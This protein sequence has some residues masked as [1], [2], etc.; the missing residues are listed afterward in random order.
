MRRPYPVTAVTQSGM[1]E[2]GDGNRVYWETAGDP[3]GKPALVLHGG[4]GS[5]SVP[6]FR[7]F[8]DPERYRIVLFDQRGCGRSTPHAGDPETDLTV[9]TT[10]HLLDDIELLRRRLEIDRWLLFGLSWGSTLALAYAES[11]PDRV[12]EIVLG[13][14]GTTRP[15]EIAWLYH[16][17]GRFL[18]EQWERFRSGAS[19]LDDDQDLVAAYRTLLEDPDA[20]VR[21]AAARRWCDWEDAVASAGRDGEMNPRYADPEFRMAFARIVTHYFANAAWLDD[22]QLI[23]NAHRLD[24]IPG[25]LV[26]GRMDL[27]SPLAT[28]WELARAWTDAD[29]IVAD[30]SG[31]SA[32]DPVMRDA[33]IA[34]TDR[35]AATG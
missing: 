12:T 23:A 32:T 11:H 20:E 9:N 14:V 30:D 15:S 28:A 24:G 3:D 18:P 16:G 6:S 34:A 2:V 26:H 29:L 21:N 25:V 13:A 4:P 33:L 8:F 17:S 1:L 19:E 5:G 31:H 35:F 10:A 7:Q 22:G 27:G